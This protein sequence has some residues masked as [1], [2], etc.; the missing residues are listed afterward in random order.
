[1]SKIHPSHVQGLTRL[2]HI[3]LNPKPRKEHRE[4]KAQRIALALAIEEGDNTGTV[5]RR[6]PHLAPD[7]Q[8]LSRRIQGLRHHTPDVRARVHMTP[9]EVAQAYLRHHF[10][11]FRA[12]SI[13]H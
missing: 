7:L 4:A 3:V 5:W 8:T 13:V 9:W 1:M 12:T 10:P 6:H 11:S 2:L